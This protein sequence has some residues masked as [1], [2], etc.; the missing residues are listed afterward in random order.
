MQHGLYRWYKGEHNIRR[1]TVRK[2]CWCIPNAVFGESEGL[3]GS[4]LLSSGI[5]LQAV[6]QKYV[7]LRTG[8]YVCSQN[9]GA[10]EK[11]LTGSADSTQIWIFLKAKLL[12]WWTEYTIFIF[13][14]ARRSTMNE[15][16]ADEFLFYHYYVVL[17]LSSM[18][19][20]SIFHPNNSPEYWSVAL[21]SSP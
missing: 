10:S 2:S 16:T 3:A 18:D 13:F 5:F 9:H 8:G 21:K 14:F 11:Y 12:E 20:V 19:E 15:N 4:A 1:R 7:W 17:F 6:K